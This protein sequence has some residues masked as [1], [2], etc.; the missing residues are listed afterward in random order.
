MT[1]HCRIPSRG[2]DLRPAVLATAFVILGLTACSPDDH[3][4]GQPIVATVGSSSISKESF[5]RLLDLSRQP[6]P[7]GNM[8]PEALPSPK[9]ILA[10]LVK[11]V[12]LGHE[13]EDRGLSVASESSFRDTLAE[14]LTREFDPTTE[15][16]EQWFEAN[17]HSFSRSAQLRFLNVP[18]P[19]GAENR[20]EKL[21]N[22]EFFALCEAAD[23]DAGGF[24][25][26]GD[27]G[28]HRTSHALWWPRHQWGPEV[29]GQDRRQ[30]WP[31]GHSSLIRAMHYRPPA[32]YAFKQVIDSC[33]L[34]M[35]EDFI[36]SEIRRI[37]MRR[38]RT[39][40]IAIVD[41]TLDFDLD[42]ASI[43][44]TEP[45]PA[46]ETLDPSLDDT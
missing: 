4:P 29:V 19:N 34:L 12:L 3:A 45:G 26:W 5:D 6:Q 11:E 9:D 18:V 41:E 39:T 30:H 25:R 31:E 36:Q 14:A 37:L 20:T 43:A 13:I 15:E 32:Q 38:A 1:D 33:R 42:P 46:L 16:L 35:T 40:A 17:K 2:R 27:I 24:R 8:P 7:F 10:E 23:T 22:R 28:W 44:R 21:T